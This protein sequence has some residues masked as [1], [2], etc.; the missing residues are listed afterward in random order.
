M[1]PIRA[2]YF[3]VA[4]LSALLLAL[5]LCAA[6]IAQFVFKLQPCELC[7]QQRQPYYF[8][9]IIALLIAQFAKTRF[10]E[11]ILKLMLALLII[12]LG[13]SAFLAVRHSGVEWGWWPAPAGCAAATQIISNVHDLQAQLG[14]YAYIPCDKPAWKLFGMLSFAN[15]NA[16]LS[17]FLLLLNAAVLA[18]F[19]LR[20]PY[21]SSSVSQ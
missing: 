12:V 21:A 20:R 8:G 19:N 13:W 15:L 4:A 17:M 9:I 14:N 16:L 18:G 3:D 5:A 10:S 2:A 11:N 6:L 7:L 1:K